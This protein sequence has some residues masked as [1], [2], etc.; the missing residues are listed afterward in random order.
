[1]GEQLDEHFAF[2]VGW[3]VKSSFYSNLQILGLYFLWQAHIR[4]DGCKLANQAPNIL[5]SVFGYCLSY[6]MHGQNINLPVCVCLS[7]FLSTRL[8]IRPL[9]GFLQFIA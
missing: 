8:Q 2:L 5:Q 3:P 4:A 6:A 9:N 1:M 7:H